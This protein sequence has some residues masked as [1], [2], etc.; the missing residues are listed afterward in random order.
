MHLSKYHAFAHECV[1]LTPGVH[2]KA[3]TH[4]QYPQTMLDYTENTG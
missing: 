4:E 1:A 3:A 2:S